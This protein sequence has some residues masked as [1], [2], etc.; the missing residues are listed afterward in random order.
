M[1]L[2][3]PLHSQPGVYLH[4]TRVYTNGFY[5]VEIKTYGYIYGTTIF[6][7][8]ILISTIKRKE[9]GLMRVGKGWDIKRIIGSRDLYVVSSEQMLFQS[10]HLINRMIEGCSSC[11]HRRSMKRC[12]QQQ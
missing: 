5:F 11:G 1:I 12:K 2:T 10:R 7:G 9:V 8:G 3:I 4:Q 6:G